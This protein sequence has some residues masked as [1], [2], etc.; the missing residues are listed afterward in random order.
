MKKLLVIAIALLMS[1]A[2]MGSALAEYGYTDLS[3]IP[4]A[5]DFTFDVTYDD[6]GLPRIVTDYPFESTGA[7]EMNLTYNKDDIRE[8]A[9]LTYFAET[10]ETA[11]TGYNGKVYPYD[12][13]TSAYEDIRNGVLTLDDAVCINTTNNNPGK[14]DWVLTYSIS[15]KAF[16]QYEEKTNSQGHNAMD[17]GGER[18]LVSF[19]N[20]TLHD[21]YYQKR[22]QDGDLC[23][24][25][26]SEGQITYAYVYLHRGEN[27]GYYTCDIV[28]GLFD[29]KKL[30][31]LGYNDND[32][33]TPAPAV[34]D[35]KTAATE[36][37]FEID[38]TT[39]VKYTG[40]GGEVTVPDGI[41]V[42]GEWAFESTAVTKVNLPETLKEIDNY[43]FYGCR[44]LTEITLPASLEKLSDAQAFAYTSNLEAI[45][46][47]EGNPNFVSVDGVLFNEDKTILLYYPAGKNRGGEYVVP[48]GTKDF[49]YTALEDTGLTAIELPLSFEGTV[50]GTD[51]SSNPDLKEIRVAEGHPNYHSVDGMLLNKYGTLVWYPAGRENETLEPEDFPAEMKAIG[52]FAF[53]GVQHLKKVT[54]PGNIT[55]IEWMCFTFSPS[56]ESIT[57]PKSVYFIDGYAFANCE[58]LKEVIILNPNVN[59]VVK[60]YRF[61]DR[62]NYSIV[63]DCPNAVLYGYKNSTTKTYAEQVGAPFEVLSRDQDPNRNQKIDAYILR[64]YQNILGSEPGDTDLDSWYEELSSGKKT[65]AEMVDQFAGSNEFKR[66][67]L[68]FADMVEK[69][70][71]TM[72][73]RSAEPAEKADWILQLQN[74]QRLKTVLNGI[75][76]SQE[77]ISLCEDCGLTPGIVKVPV[78]IKK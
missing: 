78:I 15:A 12:V 76:T 38:G 46:V 22:T 33:N 77:Y 35:K 73:D 23:I 36:S 71:L 17:V 60:D 51:F 42:L 47:A 31:E 9:V 29:G 25:Y 57:I 37:D 69:L 30:S 74:G 11:I 41:E 45:K 64:T 52:A 58:N 53:Q 26:D 70:Y 40:N 21:S 66:R 32:I 62:D 6:D 3:Q 1:I 8:A 5:V 56:L 4:Q 10:G 49:G 19:R 65:A 24:C 14:T 20:G 43:C 67:K 16:T 44:N 72:L 54:I 48:E 18:K 34:L 39:L 2:I 59:I 13:R 28:S 27:Q 61:P 75:T 7:T 63:D 50:F 55:Q 68:S